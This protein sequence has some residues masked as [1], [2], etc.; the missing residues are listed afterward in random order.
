[1]ACE[2]EAEDFLLF[3]YCLDPLALTL[4]DCFYKSKT[5]YFFDTIFFIFHLFLCFLNIIFIL[6]FKGKKLG[7]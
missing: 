7:A 1:M 2:E 3:Y 5:Y 4:F 6:F